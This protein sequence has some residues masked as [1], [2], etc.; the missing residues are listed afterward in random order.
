MIILKKV[1]N[2]DNPFDN[3][4]VTMELEDS[5]TLFEVLEV[6][7]LF[8]KASGYVYEGVLTIKESEHEN[9]Q[10]T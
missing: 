1:K 8:L 9:E 10:F 7:D 6:M 3:Y 4:E 2:Q 5:N